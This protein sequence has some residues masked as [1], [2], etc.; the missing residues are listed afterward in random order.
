MDDIDITKLQE[1]GLSLAASIV[2]LEKRKFLSAMS[3]AKEPRIKV[4]IGFRGVGKT[5][6]LLQ[7]MKQENGIYFSFDHPYVLN[8]KLYEMGKAFFKNGYKTLMI[9]EVQYYSDW[10]KDSKALYDEFQEIHIILSGSA[11]LA[12][13]PERRYEIVQIEPM[14]LKEFI[15]L[16]GKEIEDP[17]DSW[18]NSDASLNFLA[19][20][21]WLYEYYSHYLLGGG[22]PIYFTYQDKTLSAIYNSIRKSIWEDAPL[23]SSVKGEEIIVMEKILFSLATSSLGEFSINSLTKQLEIKKHGGYKLISLLEKMKILRFVLPHGKGP[24]L[25]RS[26]PKLMFYHPNLRSAICNALGVKADIGALREE[27]AV[28]SLALRGWHVRTIKGFKKN[29]DYYLEKNQQKIIIEIGG[30]SKTKQQLKG[31][32][33]KTILLDERQL[34][35]LSLFP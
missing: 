3:I 34:I 17:K 7:L 10:K 2:N 5:T 12:F 26:E 35:A 20:H 15:E 14:S 16:Q 13:E 21:Q 11:P 19:N 30:N 24:K 27:L 33:E 29:P 31:F 25:V 28:F 8:H 9:D 4:W 18:Q 23:F 6:A 32:S 22:F 1:I